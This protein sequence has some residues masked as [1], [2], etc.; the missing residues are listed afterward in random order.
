[1]H[2]EAYLLALPCLNML[3]DQQ[4]HQ[5]QQAVCTA[6]PHATD[7]VFVQ[8][9]VIIISDTVVISRLVVFGRQLCA[10]PASLPVLLSS[11]SGAEQYKGCDVGTQVTSYK[12][13]A[14]EARPW[15]A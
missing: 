4:Q 2:L 11:V 14:S 12:S 9:K 7:S 3:R 15:P 13:Y 10:T 5:H 6:P 8:F 1:M